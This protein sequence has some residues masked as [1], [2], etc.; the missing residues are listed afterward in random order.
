MSFL[1]HN[2]KLVAVALCCLGVGA[3]ASAIAGAGAATGN[4][5]HSQ[6]HFLAHRGLRAAQLRKLAGHAVHGTVVLAARHGFKTVSFDRGTVASV[7]GRQLTL[8]AGT[9]RTAKRNLTV[10]IPSA[11][12]VRDNRQ[13]ASLSALKPGQR[14]IV[15]RAPKRT[16][17]IAHTAH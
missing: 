16:L 11:A 14:V 17:V 7:S 2:C 12:R 6:R 9:A 10:T 5:S 15:I 1:R 4:G 8:T 3:G 13:A